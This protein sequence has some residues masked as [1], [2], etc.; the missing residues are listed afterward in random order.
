MSILKFIEKVCVQTIVYWAP[1]GSDG[2]GGT[3]YADP[4]E[5]KVRWDDVT[6]IIKTNDGEDVVTRAKLMVVDDYTYKG[7]VYLG[8]IQDLTI[9]ER[10]DPRSIINAYEIK[11]N[12]KTPLFRSSTQFV[13]EI[14]L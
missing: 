12:P 1:L 10:K 6:E 8:R 2:Y 4:I 5:R 9:V 7:M 11:S 14:Y 13:R 3:I